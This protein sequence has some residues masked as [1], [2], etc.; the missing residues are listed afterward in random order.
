MSE[1]LHYCDVCAI[2]NKTHERAAHHKLSMNA[3]EK[4]I[5]ESRKLAGNKR[6]RD[7]GA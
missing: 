3:A 4:E 7:I 6:K 2:I 5:I 1:F